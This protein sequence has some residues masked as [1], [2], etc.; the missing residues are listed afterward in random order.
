MSGSKPNLIFVFADQLRASSVGYA[1]QEAVRTPNIDAFA[2][3]GAQYANAVSMLPVCGP[4]RGSLITGRTP[5]ST[6]QVINDVKLRT[7]E[8]SIAHCFKAAGYDTAYV[9]KWH[10]DGP[11]RPA[12]V[13]PGP[14]R[15]GFEYWMGANFEHNYNRS[16][17]TD[18]DGN[19]KIWRDWD[20][21]AQT[22]HAIDYLKERDSQ[23][24]F[25]LFLSWGP[26]HHPYR[27]VPERYLDMYDPE[28]IQGRP[29]CPDV[30]K[31]DLQGY[32]AQTTF[33][34][35]QFQRLLDA[36]DDMGIA[37][38][39][40]VVFT[41]D[42]GDMHGS[43]GVYKKQ[44]PWNEAIKIPF[45]IRYNGVVPQ[46][47]KIEEP[48][49]VID[50]MPTLLGL[51]DVPVPDTVE[52]VDLSPYLTGAQED[53]P[54]SV[55]IMNPCPFSIGDPRG[56]DQYPDYKGMRFEYRGVITARYTYVRTIDQPWLLYD[57]LDDP[58]QMTN[59]IDD[60]KHSDTR[61]RLDGLMRA[62]MDRIGDEMHPRDTYYKR[63]GI[64]FDHRGKVVDLVENIYN[65]SG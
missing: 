38:N 61:D 4:Y 2:E 34:D 20:A 1:G 28:A 62:H 39:T 49:N 15:Q 12:P 19:L 53:P 56:E 36:L 17:F 3:S 44:W 46:G 5:T 18:N 22:S 31:E 57:N 50:V 8:V 60:P 6:G 58:Y 63:F 21:E 25:C 45:V 65:R 64:E 52:G 37:D 30:P 16:Y 24:P 14:R 47:A 11:N 7:T 9:G 27:L 35:D 41:S 10:L 51:A 23:N 13:P 40:I 55:L 29:N 26:P 43:H 33:L 48:I 59:L 54:E 42:H 32:Y